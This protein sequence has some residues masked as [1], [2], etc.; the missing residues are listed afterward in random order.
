MKA[1][2]LLVP[3]QGHINGSAHFSELLRINGWSLNFLVVEEER[4]SVSTIISNIRFG[5]KSFIKQPAT[6]APVKKESI[7]WVNNLFSWLSHTNLLAM[8]KEL[9]SLSGILQ[10]HKPDVL[11]VDSFYSYVYFLLPE[12]QHKIILINTQFNGYRDEQVP[13]INSTLHPRIKGFQTKNKLFWSI[14]NLSKTIYPYR[15][16]GQDPWSIAKQIARSKGYDLSKAIWKNKCF[17]PGIRG[18]PELSAGYQSLD[19]QIGR[20]HV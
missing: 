15:T 20:A 2:F 13:P 16:F 18:V 19:L 5:E 9:D 4:F 17:H 10:E 8:K 6:Y 11:F 1:M 7:T 12:F 14:L 3:A